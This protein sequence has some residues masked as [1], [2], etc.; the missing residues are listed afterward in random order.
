MENLLV[1]DDEKELH[2]EEALP[3]GVCGASLAEDSED[4]EEE[5][6]HRAAVEAV[7]PHVRLACGDFLLEDAQIPF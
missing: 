1:P 7:E 6:D 3:E 5:V 2:P 4:G